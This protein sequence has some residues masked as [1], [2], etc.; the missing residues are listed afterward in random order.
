MLKLVR[1]YFALKVPLIYN[2]VKF[3]SWKF[4]IKL[5]KIQYDEGMHGACKKNRHVYFQNEKMKVYLTAQV[6]S[7]SFS[8]PLTQMN[9]LKN[10]NV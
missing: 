7:M 5:N 8:T 3:I 10:N 6:L 2:N 1:N 4:I 9:I